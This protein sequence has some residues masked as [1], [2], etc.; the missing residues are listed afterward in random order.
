VGGYAGSIYV[1]APRSSQLI[2]FA[3]T[4]QGYEKSPFAYVNPEATV[5]FSTAVDLAVD[6]SVFVLHSTGKVERFSA[7]LPQKFDSST[8]DVPLKSPT[9]LFASATTKS[10]YVVDGANQRIVQFSKDGHF[11]RQLRYG[12]PENLFNGLRAIDVD[13]D[14]GKLY[15]LS[16]RKL[17]VADIPN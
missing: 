13:E 6:A 10:V 4:P 15:F 11:E 14:R 5:D 17:F 7:G 2:W 1:L 3:S 16:D 12:G 9:T 8:P